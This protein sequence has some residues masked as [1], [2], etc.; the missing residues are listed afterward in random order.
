[1]MFGYWNGF[2]RLVDLLCTVAAAGQRAGGDTPQSI[3]TT[4]VV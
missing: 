3:S 1:M 2:F 4:I